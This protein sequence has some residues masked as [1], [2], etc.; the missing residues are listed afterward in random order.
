MTMVIP[1]A[2]GGPTDVLGRMVAERMSEILHQNVIV[3]AAIAT[4]EQATPQYLGDLVKG[5]IAKWAVPIKAS[6]VTVE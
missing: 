5:E 6:G 1:F 2:A 3:G 4:D